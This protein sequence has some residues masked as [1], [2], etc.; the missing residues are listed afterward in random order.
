ML[1]THIYTFPFPLFNSLSLLF[2]NKFSLS[3]LFFY[4]TSSST[5]HLLNPLTFSSPQLITLLFHLPLSLS[6]LLNSLTSSSHQLITSHFHLPLS[7]SHLLNSLTSSSPKLIAPPISY[8]NPM[9]RF[10]FSLHVVPIILLLF[11]SQKC[12]FPFGFWL[13]LP[14]FMLLFFYLVFLFCSIFLFFGFWCSLFRWF[15]NFVVSKFFS[16]N[17]LIV[18]LTSFFFLFILMLH[19]IRLIKL[20]IFSM[21]HTSLRLV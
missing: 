3:W 5:S 18:V 13:A 17:V 10:F 11:E 14:G 7:H 16:S 20:D 6:H 1:L 21:H 12:F 4:L 15:Y 2:E 8:L 19:N 9:L